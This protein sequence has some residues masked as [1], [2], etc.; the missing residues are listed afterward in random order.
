MFDVEETKNNL[1]LFFEYCEQDLEQYI[2]QHLFNINYEEVMIF[3]KQIIEACHYYTSKGYLHRDIKP[4][5]ILLKN[6]MI[7]VADFGLATEMVDYEKS[8]TYAGSP[9]YM[10]P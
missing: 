1:Y 7:K 6:K 4:A 8:V 10:A 9:H 2:R 5:N 3:S